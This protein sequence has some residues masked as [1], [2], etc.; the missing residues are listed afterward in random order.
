[1]LQYGDREW[2]IEAAKARNLPLPKWHSERPVVPT[3][4]LWFFRAWW[5]LDT[6][7]SYTE[8]MPCPI[9]WTAVHEYATY[10]GVDLDYLYELISYM[11]KEFLEYRAKEAKHNMPKPSGRRAQNGR[12]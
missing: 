3:K 2:E 10:H 1:M 5:D 4:L 6:C 12:W 8:G 9:P 7:R 11:D